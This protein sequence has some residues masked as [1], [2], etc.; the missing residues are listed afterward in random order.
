MAL[1]LRKRCP[2]PPRRFRILRKKITEQTHVKANMKFLKDKEREHNKLTEHGHK[3]FV[4][5][6]TLYLEKA[7]LQ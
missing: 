2:R 6:Y 4:I 5:G 3:R 7:L 1:S